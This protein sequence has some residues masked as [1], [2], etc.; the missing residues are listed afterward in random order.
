MFVSGHYKTARLWEKLLHRAGSVLPAAALTAALVLLPSLATAHQ[1][2]SNFTASLHIPL[3][4]PE[5]G[6]GPG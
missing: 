1:G 6:P 2:T 3:P 4:D 5:I